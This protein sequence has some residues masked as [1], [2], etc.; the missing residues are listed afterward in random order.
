MNFSTSYINDVNSRAVLL[1]QQNRHMDAICWLRRGLRNL[2]SLEHLTY[3]T[4]QQSLH[5]AHHASLKCVDSIG[6]VIDV[7]G[8]ERPAYSVEI[9]EVRDTIIRFA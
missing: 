3:D 9:P 1:L 5:A 7:G 4:Q 6:M 2:A 8:E